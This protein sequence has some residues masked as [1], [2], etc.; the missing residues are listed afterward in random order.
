MFAIRRIV[1]MTIAS[2]SLVVATMYILFVSLGLGSTAEADHPTGIHLRS[3][4]SSNVN[5]DECTLIE[6]GSMAW[7]TARDRIRYTLWIDNPS[8][9]WDGLAGNKVYFIEGAYPCNQDPNRSAF[10]LEYW[11]HSSGCGGTSCQWFSNY[12]GSHGG[13]NDYNYGYV[14]FKTSHINGST[15]LYH[16]VISHETG[17][18]LGLADGDGSCPGSIMHSAYYGCSNLEW[19]SSGDRDQVTY[20]ANTTSY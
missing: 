14:R 8:E 10:E 11:V 3:M 7:S 16:H 4:H 12:W 15:S 9:D 20:E 5:E 19:P 6:D 2:F 1:R 13:Y 18:H 17:H